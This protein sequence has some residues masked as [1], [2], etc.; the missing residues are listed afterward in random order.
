[1]HEGGFVGVPPRSRPIERVFEFEGL[2]ESSRICDYVGEL[3]DHLWGDGQ[4]LVL[5]LS[6]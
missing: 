2:L 5:M 3:G 1:L 4:E 6:S